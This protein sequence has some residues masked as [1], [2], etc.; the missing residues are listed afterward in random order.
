MC[1]LDEFYK[2]EQGAPCLNLISRIVADAYPVEATEKE[3]ADATERVKLRRRVRQL[4]ALNERLLDEQGTLREI[5]HELHFW[6]RRYADG[7]S[8]YV[9]H[10]INMHTRILLKLGVPLDYT[11]GTVFA[12]D[13]MGRAFDGLKPDEV[14]EA[15]PIDYKLEVDETIR[16]LRVKLAEYRYVEATDGGI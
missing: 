1:W 16:R 11:D 2:P 12:R 6:A 3:Q 13:G 7:R 9:P 8:T 15:K 5:I 10:S 14:S 4:E